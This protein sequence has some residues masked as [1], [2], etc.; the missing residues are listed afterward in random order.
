MSCAGFS[1]NVT[2]RSCVDVIAVFLSE[3]QVSLARECR[4]YRCVH[5]ARAIC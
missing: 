2:R 4:S 5:R 1:Q 3:M